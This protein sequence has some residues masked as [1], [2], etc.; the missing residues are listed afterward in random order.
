MLILLFAV[1]VYTVI[2]KNI[3]YSAVKQETK[4]NHLLGK[5]ACTSSM[6]R[7]LAVILGL[8]VGHLWT[9]AS[10]IPDFLFCKC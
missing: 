7:K 10:S 1:W 6:F 4:P 5:L 2:I 3:I 8:L 9:A